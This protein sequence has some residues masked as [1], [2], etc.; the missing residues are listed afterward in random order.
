MCR[1][2]KHL[3]YEVGRLDSNRP[4]TR[5]SET[6]NVKLL[7]LRFRGSGDRGAFSL[8]SLS[9]CWICFVGKPDTD[10][11]AADRYYLQPKLRS[12]LDIGRIS[13][14]L[15]IC[16]RGH[17]IDCNAEGP[18]T[19]EHAFPGLR[20][21]RFID[22]KRNCLV[23]MQSICKY[24]ALSYVWGAV[25][26]FR[27]TKANKRELS[28]SGG[29]E[30]VWEMLPRTIK[31][32]V[33]FMRMLGLRYLWVDALCLLQNDQ[34][35]LELGVAVMDQIY[36]RSWLTIIAAC[37]HDANAGLPGV[38]EG[39]RKPS[40]L[41]MEVKEGVSLGVYTGLDLLYKNSVHNSR[42]WT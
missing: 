10:S 14:W 22:V 29:I 8:D 3:W 42:A 27:L 9:D 24:T 25:P 33:E 11:L 13:H 31:D 41:T 5:L 19:F 16:T 38:L 40:N 26:N 23:E 20:V 28:V 34:E 32:T 15:S 6:T 2:V 12:E 30:A 17:T 1:L 18:I 4:P 35:D 37:G 39:S 36:E 7:W 21:L